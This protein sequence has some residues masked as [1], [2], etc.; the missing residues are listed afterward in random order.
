MALACACNSTRSE[1]LDA[2]IASAVEGGRVLALND[3]DLRWRPALEALQAA[4]ANGEDREARAVLAR[5]YA[6]RPTG[7]ALELAQAFERILDGR[8]AVA[9]IELKVEAEYRREQGEQGFIVVWFTARTDDTRT[10]D[11]APGPCNLRVAHASIDPTGAET[12]SL[13]TIPVQAPVRFLVTAGAPVRLPLAHMPFALQKGALASRATIDMELRSGAVRVDEQELPAMRWHIATGEVVLLKSELAGLD[14]AGAGELAAH[15]LDGKCDAAEALKIAVRLPSSEREDALDELARAVRSIPGPA[16]IGL[17]PA[18]R[19]LVP[20]EN[21][22][23]D[24]DLWRAYLRH[25]AGRLGAPPDL[26]LPRAR[27]AGT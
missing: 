26:R 11:V 8:A 24:A 4:V 22:G 7:S 14:L 13:Q 20:G 6:T 23:Q 10:F 16:L 3:V 15:V 5:L 18:L 19:W 25:R 12:R 2:R 1:P 21:F 17:T 9:A 27:A